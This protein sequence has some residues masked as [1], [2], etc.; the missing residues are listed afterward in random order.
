MSLSDVVPFDVLRPQRPLRPREPTEEDRVRLRA[1]LDRPPPY[2]VSDVI[3]DHAFDSRPWCSWFEFHGF[4]QPPTYLGE[5]SARTAPDDVG[6]VQRCGCEQCAVSSKQ[7][8]QDGE[9]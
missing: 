4:T 8:A 9:P 1:W 7:A 5:R 6:A 3:P 2:A